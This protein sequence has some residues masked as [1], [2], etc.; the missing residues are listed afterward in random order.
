MLSWWLRYDNQFYSA[1]N[2]TAFCWQDSGI[3]PRRS[4][5]PVSVRFEREMTPSIKYRDDAPK[6]L[7][8]WILSLVLVILVILIIILSSC[9]CRARRKFSPVV[10]AVAG[11]ENVYLEQEFPH[12]KITRLSSTVRRIKDH[13]DPPLLL[14]NPKL[15]DAG[16]DVGSSGGVNLPV[17]LQPRYSRPP[18][19]INECGLPTPLPLPPPLASQYFMRSKSVGFTRN[20]VRSGP[21]AS[22]PRS[23]R[24]LHWEDVNNNNNNNNNNIHSHYAEETMKSSG[25][26]V[27]F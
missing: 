24:K 14:H 9:I 11:R 1:T 18:A 19:D 21:R 26:S 23:I 27:Y 15:S 17:P 6:I 12:E 2:W 7:L 3:P 16:S 8:M 22:I 20:R 4:S 5:V 10:A 13:H 25:E